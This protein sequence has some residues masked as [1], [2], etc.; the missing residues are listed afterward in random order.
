MAIRNIQ[1]G[2]IYIISTKLSCHEVITISKSRFDPQVLINKA[3]QVSKY[4]LLGLSRPTELFYSKELSN[5]HQVESLVHQFLIHNDYC[6]MAAKD[7]QLSFKD[8]IKLIEMAIRGEELTSKLVL[9]LRNTRYLSGEIV[10]Y[11]KLGAYFNGSCGEVFDP[12]QIDFE[13]AFFCH[14]KGYESD[15]TR[16]LPLL[17][18]CYE[19]GIGVE[20]DG[21]K[22]L[23]LYKEIYHMNKIEGIENLF[24]IYTREKKEYKTSAVLVDFFNWC[25]KKI[26]HKEVHSS[27]AFD[28]YFC[29]HDSLVRVLG[30]FVWESYYYSGNF[31]VI[32]P[33]LNYFLD[34]R[35]SLFKRL[36]KDSK[37]LKEQNF[38]ELG[39]KLE[40]CAESFCF[41][42]DQNGPKAA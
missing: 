42:L 21:P 29:I 24:R 14:Y 35:I 7:Y 8:A 33:F 12:F 4:G 23:E 34:F 5:C 38:D 27:E 39:N 22:A 15:D 37:K 30:S 18:N 2:H 1:S 13:V 41:F 28:H 40:K 25:E 17:A 19:D 6:A 26:E 36:Q 3:N 20:K 16:C 11:Y 9:D 31:D 10:N 32:R